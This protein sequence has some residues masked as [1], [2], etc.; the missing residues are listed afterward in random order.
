MPLLYTIRCK[1][2]IPK[3]KKVSQISIFLS[4]LFHILLNFRKLLKKL[5]D[6]VDFMYIL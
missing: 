3:L 1:K 5:S 6:V 4:E 2:G